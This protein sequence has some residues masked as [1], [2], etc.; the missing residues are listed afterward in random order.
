MSYK[1]YCNRSH[2]AVSGE[3]TVECHLSKFGHVV[4][5]AMINSRP[6]LVLI[7]AVI[8]CLYMLN[9]SHSGFVCNITTVIPS[10][11]LTLVV[12]DM[13]P[14][15]SP[16]IKSIL[17][18]WT[19]LG[20]G[21]PV[22][23]ICDQVTG[24][25]TLK[26]IVLES[27]LFC[28]YQRIIQSID[29]SKFMAKNSPPVI[30]QNPPNVLNF[31]EEQ[32]SNQC[33]N[34]TYDCIDISHP[35]YTIPAVLTALE[36]TN[37]SIF[38][39]NSNQYEQFD[40]NVSP[41]ADSCVS[42]IESVMQFVSQNFLTPELN[43]NTDGVLELSTRNHTA[44]LELHNS[45]NCK[46]MWLMKT[47][48]NNHVVAMPTKGVLKQGHACKVV[49]EVRGKIKKEKRRPMLVFEYSPVENN[50]Q[51]FKS[52]VMDCFNLRKLKD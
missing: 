22:D 38:P 48:S 19:F 5:N 9:G 35:C 41:G 28:V 39:F 51:Y 21:I 17:I 43:V 2:N 20:V 47:N 10:V 13:N 11:L 31:Q 29:E 52:E 33:G 36:N 32:V 18:F 26:F 50:A 8:S 7:I 46:L 16:V 44:A 37:Q 49:I 25:F 27:T 34:V 6:D 45:G 3:Q 12:K 15:P 40:L 30:K 14:I 24:Y 42:T 23:Y 1:K 4:L